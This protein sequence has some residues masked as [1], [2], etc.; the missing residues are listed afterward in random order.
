MSVVVR[1]LETMSAETATATAG[2]DG[3]RKPG[4]AAAK[5]QTKS[6]AI[7]FCIDRD[8]ITAATAEVFARHA[9][10]ARAAWNWALADFNTTQ[11]AVTDAVRARAAAEAGDDPDKIA[12]L[13]ADAAWRKAA[14]SAARKETAAAHPEYAIAVNAVATGYRFRTMTKTEDSSWA[15]WHAEQHGVQKWSVNPVFGDLGK[16]IERAYASPAPFNPRRKPR[17]DGMRAGWPRFKSKADTDQGFSILSG[18]TSPV[19][20]AH[21]IRLPLKTADGHQITVRVHEHTKKLQSLLAKGAIAD[22]KTIRVTRRGGRWYVNFVIDVP[23][24]HT[25]RPATRRQ[26]TAGGIG[27]DQGITQ[28]LALSDGSFIANPRHAAVYERRVRK[29]QRAMARKRAAKPR[30]TVP[31]SRYR[32]AR[33]QYAAAQRQLAT[34]RSGF[35]HR[36]TAR[37]AA[38]YALVAIEDLQTGNMTRSAKGTVEAPGSRVRQKAG[39]N[40]VI[41]D[42]GFGELARMLEYKARRSG[43]D[44]IKVAAAYTSQTCHQC[45]HTAKENRETQAAFRCV[46]CGHTANADTNAARN[47]LVLA[48][49]RLA[50]D[51]GRVETR[52]EGDTPATAGTPDERRRAERPH[53]MGTTTRRHPRN[54]TRTPAAA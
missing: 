20:S 26:R 2:A 31:S 49:A 3:A 44:L 43:A 19:V 4:R 37:L 41:L 6:M 11:T 18:K 42:A 51:A 38:R 48:Q 13:F 10:V 15:W 35:L 12:V 9:G 39:L 28:R 22:Q 32:R 30:G 5:T 24:E 45:G 17:K 47:V 40:R 25:A 21:R 16:A 52:P 50:S 46:Q 8:S 27:V 34:S 53:R 23:L 14:Y 7:R 36:E 29:A 54:P 1:R 33:E